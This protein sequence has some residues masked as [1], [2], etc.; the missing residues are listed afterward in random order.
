MNCRQILRLGLMAILGSEASTLSA[1]S[2]PQGM[3]NVENL[4]GCFDV[5]YRFVEDGVH[6]LFAEKYTLD[7]PIREWIGFQQEEKN[8]FILQHAT[9][10]ADQ[11]ASH[12]HEVW[13]Y[14]PD[15]ESWTQ[16]VW[17]RSYQ[18][19]GRKLRYQCTAPW[20]MNRWECHAGKAEKPFRDSGAPF[21]FNRTDYKR[22]DRENIL[23]VT[24]S[25]W[26]QN[27]SNKKLSA[28]DQII[29]YELGWITYRRLEDKSCKAALERFPREAVDK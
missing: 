15:K 3:G 2:L 19:E 21:G 4:A 17:S 13:K 9:L 18:D 10:N 22:L 1:E 11:V 5:T 27:E 8:A 16:E 25:G 28:S 23:L 29:S 12:F 26:V 7:E 24:P 6:D 20:K 14:H